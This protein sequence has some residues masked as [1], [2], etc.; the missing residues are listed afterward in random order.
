MLVLAHYTRKLGYGTGDW[1]TSDGAVYHV[2]DRGRTLCG[3]ASDAPGL[4]QGTSD[5][6]WELR[7][8]SGQG[9]SCQRCWRILEHE[10]SQDRYG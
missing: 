1:N 8:L 6:G 9:V 5:R 3:F 2:A 4:H 7:E 10:A